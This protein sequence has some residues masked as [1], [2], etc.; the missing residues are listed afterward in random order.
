MHAELEERH[1][2]FCGRRRILRHLV[3][4]VAPPRTGRLVVDVGCGTGANIA[5]LAGDYDCVGIDTSADAIAFARGRFP[6]IRFV[7]GFAPADVRQDLARGSVAMFCD[8]LEHVRDDVALLSGVLAALPAGAHVLITVPADASLWSE[9]DVSFGHYR[10]YDVARLAAAWADLPVTVR[11]LS[12]FNARLY[13]V[14]RGVRTVSRLRGRASGDAGTDLSLPPAQANRALAALFGGE[15]VRLR[16]AIDGG[17]R[18][19]RSGVS[20]VALLRREPGAIVP[21]RMPAGLPPDLHDPD[22]GGGR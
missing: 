19:Y 21:G 9:H 1:W 16:R 2:W 13:P 4:A 22:A 14:V 5:S 11:L 12:H 3:E 18:P 10:R 20:L 17:A 8:V 7:Q 6:A 15:A